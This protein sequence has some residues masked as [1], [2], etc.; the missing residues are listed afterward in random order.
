MNK[1]MR[2][3]IARFLYFKNRIIFYVLPP[4]YDIRRGYIHR[5]NVPHFDDMDNKDEWQKEVY[6]RAR[7]IT[8]T[9]NYKSICDIGCGS[10]YKLLKYFQGYE[11]TGVEVEP[12]LGKLIK[13]YPN[14]N[15]QSF[16]NIINKHFDLVILADVI[17]H[18]KEPDL[19]FKDFLN[20]VSF[21]VIIV[22]TP[23]RSIMNDIYSFGPP[24]NKHHYREW[25]SSEFRKFIE[26]FLQIDDQYIS[27]TAQF[28]QVIVGKKLI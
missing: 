11:I 23:D 22:S 9:N 17:E 13:M 15:W 16:N 18:L 1:L 26:K 12:T 4:K 24:A 3:I 6:E 5:K 20:K 19:F 25:T 2:R 21:N 7:D 8:I 10:G 27:N 28:T 14:N